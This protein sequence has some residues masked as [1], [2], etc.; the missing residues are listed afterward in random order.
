V[1]GVVKSECLETWLL[2]GWQQVDRLQPD[3]KCSLGRFEVGLPDLRIVRDD[4]KER[5]THR[6][7]VTELVVEVA[8]ARLAYR[9]FG[10]LA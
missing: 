5:E 4:R 2:V 6:S 1:K 7:F 10:E 3:R 8:K 9:S